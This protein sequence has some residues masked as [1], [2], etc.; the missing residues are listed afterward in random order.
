MAPVFEEYS[1]TYSSATFIK[2]DVDQAADIAQMAGVR[3]MPT[4]HV[5]VGGQKVK[6]IVGADKIKLEESI[7]SVAS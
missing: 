6:E 1:K 4:F 2:V 3:A 7:K 5:Y